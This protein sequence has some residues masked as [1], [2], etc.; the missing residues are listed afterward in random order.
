MTDREELI[1]RTADTLE[2]AFDRALATPE[3]RAAYEGLRRTG[4]TLTINGRTINPETGE[5]D[6]DADAETATDRWRE[7]R[8]E[9]IVWDA[10]PDARV[11]PPGYDL[12]N[13]GEQGTITYRTIPLPYVESSLLATVGAALIERDAKLGSLHRWGFRIAYLFAEDF[14]KEQGAPRLWKLKKASPDTTWALGQ[15][16]ERRVVDLFL[17]VNSRIARYAEFTNWQL[18]ATLHTALGHARVRQGGLSVEPPSPVWQRYLLRRYGLWE[19]DMKALQEVMAL[20]EADQLP[21]WE[22]EEDD[23]DE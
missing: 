1:A 3:G 16:R 4:G 17:F 15:S 8:E 19:P 12:I 13:I 18:Q 5:T 20:A 22:D 9:G 10:D 2:G 7:R 23:G 6:A 14:G 21:L 11:Y